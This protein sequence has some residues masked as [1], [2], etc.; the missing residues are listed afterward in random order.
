[1]LLKTIIKKIESKYQLNLY[2]YL[3]NVGLLVVDFYIN[4]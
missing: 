3:D 4:V 2:Y 1:M